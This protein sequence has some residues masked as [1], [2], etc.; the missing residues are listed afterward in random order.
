[1]R[2]RVQSKKCSKA[3]KFMYC[4]NRFLNQSRRELGQEL[5]RKVCLL[6]VET[7][8]TKPENWDDE[9]GQDASTPLH[10]ASRAGNITRVLELLKKPGKCCMLIVF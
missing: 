7:I 8:V 4:R 2:E 5:V 10:K 1:M 3:R 6:Q 9:N